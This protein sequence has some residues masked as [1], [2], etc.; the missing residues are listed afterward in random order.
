SARSEESA[1]ALKK[2]KAS[3]LAA[4]LDNQIPS[5]QSDGGPVQEVPKVQLLRPSD[6]MPAKPAEQPTG[7]V[8]PKIEF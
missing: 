7:P 5:G 1:N 4:P 8:L 2:F 3:G 6:T